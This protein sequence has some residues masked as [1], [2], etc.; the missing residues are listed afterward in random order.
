MLG[1]VFARFVEKSPISVMVR[2]TLE[3]VLGADQLDAWFARTAQK[4]Y[5]RTLLFPTVYAWLSQVV[6]RI[7]PSVR[8]AYRDH[9]D[10]V[11]ASLISVYNTLNG[12]ETHTAA[13]L[14]RYSAAVLTPLSE[15]LDGKRAPWLPGY[16]VKIIDGNCIEASARRLKAWR[17]VQAGALPGK[18]LVISEPAQG[19]GSAVF[20]CEDGHAQERSMF[21]LVLATVHADDLWMQDRNFCPCAFLCESDR[22][23]ACFITRQHDGL[24]FEVVRGLRAVGRIETGH[25]AAQRV[26]VWDA[27]GGAHLLRRI[28]V[29]LEQATRDGDRVLDILTNGPLRKASATRVARL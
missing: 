20:P 22:R 18:S 4:Q 11:G 27:Q 7:K 10:E 13:A 16:R 26:Q 24:P 3:R 2:G 28:R 9:E 1:K 25:V 29:K 17:A 12:V 23:D 6:F 15:Q 8:A 19:L 5:T 21:G 14:V